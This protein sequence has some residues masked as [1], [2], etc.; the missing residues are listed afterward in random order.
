MKVLSLS[1]RIENRLKEILDW[2][3]KGKIEERVKGWGYLAVY[4][5]YCCRKLAEEGKIERKKVNE[6]VL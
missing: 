6:S 5:D 1:K 3:H 4:R 2:V